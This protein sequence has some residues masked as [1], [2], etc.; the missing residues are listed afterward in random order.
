MGLLNALT[1]FG[2]LVLGGLGLGHDISAQ[3][4]NLRAAKENAELNY[5]AE[6]ENLAWQREAQGITW[7]REDNAVQRRVADLK[8]AGLSPVLAAGS[9][10]SS[11]APR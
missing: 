3:G 9:A 11:S 4:Q 1:G 6:Q 2:G 5:K 10:A 7:S 8:A